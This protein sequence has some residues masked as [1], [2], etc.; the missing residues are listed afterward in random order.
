MKQ[1]AEARNSIEL[2]SPQLLNWGLYVRA[3]HYPL[4][5][6]FLISWDSNYEKVEGLELPS[7]ATSYV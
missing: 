1:L 6:S 7:N 4:T 3:L 5:Y 2:K